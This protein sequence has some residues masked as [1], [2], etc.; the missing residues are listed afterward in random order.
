MTVP[1]DSSPRDILVSVALLVQR[2]ITLEWHEAI[3]IVVEIAEVLERSDKKVLPTYQD[4][5]LTPEGSVRFVRE[6]RG[7]PHPSDSSAARLR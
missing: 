2:G 5:V 3:A 1:R 4:W 6:P 7:G